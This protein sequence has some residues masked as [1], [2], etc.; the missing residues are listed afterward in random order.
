MSIQLGTGDLVANKAKSFRE[1]YIFVVESGQ[2]A[3]TKIVLD[4]EFDI[5]PTKK[6]VLAN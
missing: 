6:D 1:A 3:M 4:C 2:K 5:D